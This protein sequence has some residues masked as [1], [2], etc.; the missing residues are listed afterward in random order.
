M[1][2]DIYTMVIGGFIS[3]IINIICMTAAHLYYNLF[4]PLMAA[5][6]ISMSSITIMFIVMFKINY[7][8]YCMRLKDEKTN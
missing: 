1:N 3:F 8:K 6:I 5:I 4:P 7:N 2:K